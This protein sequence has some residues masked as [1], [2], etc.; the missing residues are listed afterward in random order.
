MSY[1]P[2]SDNLEFNETQLAAQIELLENVRDMINNL[3]TSYLDYVNSQL[4]PDWTTD[5]GIKS[6]DSLER[7]A[8]NNIQEFITYFDNRIADLREAL[9]SVKNINAA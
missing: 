1:T 5:N 4:R 7:F 3:K 8:N 9:Q 6:V 2:K